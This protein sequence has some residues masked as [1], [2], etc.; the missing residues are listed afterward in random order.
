[1]LP[2]YADLHVHGAIISGLLF[3]GMDVVRGQD[4]GQCGKDDEILLIDAVPEGRLM[5]TNDHDF[6][7]LDAAWQSTGRSHAGIVYWHQNKYPVGEAIKRILAYASST[8]PAD[9]TNVV[10]FL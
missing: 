9:A 5:L 3:R 6:L 8:A 10:H 2:C 4:R 7:A 1:M